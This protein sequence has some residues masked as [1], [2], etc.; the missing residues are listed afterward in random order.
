MNIIY[1]GMILS[2]GIFTEQRGDCPGALSWIGN[3]SE[4]KD[5][6]DHCRLFILDPNSF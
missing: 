2:N 4:F 3:P 1:R 6:T 5:L